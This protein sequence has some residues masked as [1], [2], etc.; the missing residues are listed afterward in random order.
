MESFA[1]L[2][3]GGKATY[4][5]SQGKACFE[6]KVISRAPSPYEMFLFFMKDKNTSDVNFLLFFYFQ[7]TEKITVKHISKN[8]EIH[9][10]Q[11]G[12]SPA[13]GSLLLGEDR[14]PFSVA[15]SAVGP[16]SCVRSHGRNFPLADSAQFTLIDLFKPTPSVC[17]E[18]HKM[19]AIK[20]PLVV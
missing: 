18:S 8:M 6:M 15:L 19:S 10:V 13:T 17:A 9:D 3:S 12:W 11:V 5:V 4:G 1:Y 7:I 16:V 20:S 2:W 14:A